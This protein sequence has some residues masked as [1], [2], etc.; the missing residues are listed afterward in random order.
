MTQSLSKGRKALFLV[1]LVLIL[2]PVMAASEERLL[3]TDRKPPSTYLEPSGPAKTLYEQAKKFW[4]GGDF[5]KAAET[6]K[7][8]TRL[9]PDDFLAFGLMGFAY[10]KA[11]LYDEAL[12][13]FKEAV[14][15]KPDFMGNYLGLGECYLKLNRPEE[16]I[17]SF[18]Q[19]ICLDP[20]DASA[21]SNLAFAYGELASNLAKRGQY[22]KGIS[23]FK[24]MAEEY[25]QAV[26]LKPDDAI[27]HLGL[28]TAYLMFGDRGAALEEYKIL[29]TLDEKRANA[30]FNLIY[31]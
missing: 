19:A 2:L 20:D 9:R 16:A 23:L 12:I 3:Q 30:L 10:E 6:Y 22:E 14:R 29:Q 27:A 7:Q 21:H 31:Q 4:E 28:G 15:L 5:A 13:A 18:K 25:K 11:G 17:E 1:G 26:R 8:I 24:K